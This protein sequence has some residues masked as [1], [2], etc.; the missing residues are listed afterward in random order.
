VCL[1]FFNLKI[2]CECSERLDDGTF[3]LKKMQNFLTSLVMNLLILIKIMMK[4]KCVAG[5]WMIIL[6]KTEIKCLNLL[7]IK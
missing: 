1:E 4:V 7:Q 2:K 3:V 5:T 6:E